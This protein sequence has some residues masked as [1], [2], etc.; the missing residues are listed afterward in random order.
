MAFPGAIAARRQ[1]MGSC[2]YVN[3]VLVLVVATCVAGPILSEHYAK[4]ML[5]EPRKSV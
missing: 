3:A 1:V 4:G 2:G 5:G